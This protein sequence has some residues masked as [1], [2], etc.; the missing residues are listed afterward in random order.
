MRIVDPLGAV[1]APGDVGEIQVQG[2]NVI[3]AYWNRED[4]TADSFVEA[5]D[6]TWLKTGDMGYRDEEGFVFISDRLKDMIISGGENIYPAQV[7]QEISQLDAVAAVAVIGVP[8]EKW[9]EVPRAVIVVREG[10]ELTEAQVLE[11]L[12]GK[13]ARYKIP[14]SVVFTEDMPRT[15]SGKIRKPDLRKQFG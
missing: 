6:G 4:A 5:E 1:C 9:G 10:H 2:P 8:S 3:K 11:H 14:K 12:D 15:A 13:L 7:E